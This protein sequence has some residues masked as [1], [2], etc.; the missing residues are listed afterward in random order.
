MQLLIEFFLAFQGLLDQLQHR[1]RQL[2]QRGD[3]QGNYHEI[4]KSQALH[5]ERTIETA[6]RLPVSN[7]EKRPI[8]AGIG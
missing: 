4:E 7:T 6:N 2:Q 3:A 5:S 1:G 8:P